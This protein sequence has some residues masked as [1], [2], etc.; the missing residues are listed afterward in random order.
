MNKIINYHN[1]LTKYFMDNFEKEFNTNNFDNIINKI[2]ITAGRGLRR[3]NSNNNRTGDKFHHFIKL[4]RVL[5]I[6]RTVILI[7]LWL[8]NCVKGCFAAKHIDIIQARKFKNLNTCLIIYKIIESIII[9]CI[10]GFAA[11]K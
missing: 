9:L 11:L 1:K 10:I 6:I 8:I 4:F 5:Y 2:Y 3:H 7:I